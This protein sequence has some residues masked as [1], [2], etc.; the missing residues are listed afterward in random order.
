MNT[1][2]DVLEKIKVEIMR[3][4]NCHTIILYGSRARGDFKDTSD[5][6]IIAIRPQGNLIKDSRLFD[7][8]Y[9]DA[10]IYSDKEIKHLDKSFLRARDGIVL[11]QKKE[12]GEQLLSNIQKMY[13]NGPPLTPSWEK[14]D[15]V[16]WQQ[17]MYGRIQN[18]DIESN[19]RKNWLLYSILEYY[20]QLRDE[21]YLGPNSAFVWLKKNDIETYNAFEKCAA[22]P[23]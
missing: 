15:I 2:Q 20:F 6:D 7:G 8:C 22:T 5:F 13:K 23:D 11:C 21:W 12:I 18:S 10:F 14:K 16:L 1:H 3:K 9:L 4:Y 19:F 17:K